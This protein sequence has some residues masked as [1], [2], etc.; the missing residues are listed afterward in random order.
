M[1][2]RG[3]ATAPDLAYGTDALNQKVRFLTKSRNRNLEKIVIKQVIN[4]DS[5]SEVRKV[6]E[7]MHAKSMQMCEYKTAGFMVA[8]LEIVRELVAHRRDPGTEFTRHELALLMDARPPVSATI[9]NIDAL[10]AAQNKLLA[11]L[12]GLNGE[13]AY[14]SAKSK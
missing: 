12:V 1:S 2:E 6:L 7:A 5:L 14:L 10:T 13:F 9:E 4:D 3:G 11:M 8:M